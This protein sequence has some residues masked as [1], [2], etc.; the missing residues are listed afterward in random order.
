MVRFV[1][2]LG[3]M[4]TLVLYFYWTSRTRVY[5]EPDLRN[6]LKKQKHAALDDFWVQVYDT[7]SIEEARKIQFK[8]QDMNI[9]CFIY[10]QGKKDVYGNAL[11]HYGISVPRKA[12]EKA[13]SVLAQIIL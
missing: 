7:D 12:S 2:F 10:E 8:F 9:Q 5:K 1:T 13:Q 3:V 11:K 6:K 4:A